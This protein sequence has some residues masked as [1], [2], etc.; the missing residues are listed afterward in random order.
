MSMGC[1]T[2]TNGRPPGFVYS[3][4]G[5]VV[6]MCGGGH[7]PGDV[8]GNAFAALRLDRLGMVLSVCVVPSIV[9]YGWGAVPLRHGG[10]IAFQ[11][12]SSTR[13]L[14]SWSA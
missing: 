6:A 14:N 3:R 1:C 11:L 12:G 10:H 13:G 8:L 7:G 4:W 2:L 9:R 5:R